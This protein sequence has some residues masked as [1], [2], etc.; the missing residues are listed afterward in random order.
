MKVER[1]ECKRRQLRCNSRIFSS[2]LLKNHART[3][4]S[5]LRRSSEKRCTSVRAAVLS[6][7]RR[8]SEFD[9]HG[10]GPTQ[11]V[12]A[13][14]STARCHRILKLAHTIA[15]LAESEEIQSANLAEA[16]QYRPKIMAG[17]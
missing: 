16:L 13:Y 10:D 11:F 17:K 3:I 1:F 7:A 15:N 2:S 4:S 8:R 6:V 5:F 12:C 14:V 9:A